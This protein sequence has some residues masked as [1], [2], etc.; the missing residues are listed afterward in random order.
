VKLQTR[1]ALWTFVVT[2]ALSATLN[3]VFASDSMRAR[4]DRLRAEG[5]R[6]ALSTISLYDVLRL[7]GS[8]ADKATLQ[9]FLDAAVKGTP[10]SARRRGRWCSTRTQRS[11]RAR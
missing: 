5:K 8:D 11:S 2:L 9:S 1:I 7:T 4:Y 3:A 6:V 10:T